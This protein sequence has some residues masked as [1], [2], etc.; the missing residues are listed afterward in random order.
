MRASESS[1]LNIHLDPN[2]EDFTREMKL[3]DWKK[4]PLD[5]SI[6]SSLILEEL[7]NREPSP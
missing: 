7:F 6:P 2:P 3:Y 5:S 1:S 4:K